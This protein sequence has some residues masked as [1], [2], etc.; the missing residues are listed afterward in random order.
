M[1]RR[2]TAKPHLPANHCGFRLPAASRPCVRSLS[3]SLSPTSPRPARFKCP[4]APAVAVFP[5][6]SVSQS[7]SPRALGVPAIDVD[8][9]P[10]PGTTVPE[11]ARPV[12]PRS[13]RWG[14]ACRGR[15]A[16]SC[17]RCGRP[18]SP[19]PPRRCSSP[20]SSSSSSR[21]TSTPPSPRPA[22]AEAARQPPPP[23]RVPLRPQQPAT[24]T[25]GGAAGAAPGAKRPP[26][27]LAL[28]APA[29]T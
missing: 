4:G 1:E 16:S 29:A 7:S 21:R 27:S 6:L 11:L 24:V 17:R 26:K 12:R 10:R 25:P 9:Q 15:W 3:F 2:F 18:R 13:R 28:R 5:A 8:Q 23:H 20:R 19:S 14:S 22:A